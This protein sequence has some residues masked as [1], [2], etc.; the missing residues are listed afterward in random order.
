MCTHSKPA[1]STQPGIHCETQSQNKR[2]LVKRLLKLNWHD[3]SI[4][5]LL[6]WRY[7]AENSVLQRW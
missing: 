3:F 5:I 7:T 4:L 2:K 6:K 1:W